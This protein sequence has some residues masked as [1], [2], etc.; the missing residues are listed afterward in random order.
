MSRPSRA[1]SKDNWPFLLM[2]SQRPHT[3]RMKIRSREEALIE[4]PF[5]EV[6]DGKW[7]RNLQKWL[8]DKDWNCLMTENAKVLYRF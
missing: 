6:E 5:L 3:P 1:K 7:L 2:I 4:T 8:S